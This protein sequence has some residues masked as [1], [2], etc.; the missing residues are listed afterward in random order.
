MALPALGPR[1]T[2]AIPPPRAVPQPETTPSSA[3]LAPSKRLPARRRRSPARVLGGWLIALYLRVTT[4][5][6]RSARITFDICIA[7][8]A[9]M[10]PLCLV[11]IGIL[12]LQ[13]GAV[14]RR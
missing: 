14:V 10:L 2:V 13:S 3:P 9:I 8:V 11:G 1:R 12:V 5:T 4:T 7:G 6:P